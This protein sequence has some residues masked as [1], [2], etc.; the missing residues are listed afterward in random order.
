[1]AFR[2][3]LFAAGLLVACVGALFAPFLG[4]LG[5]IAH[6][7][8]GPEYQWW[9]KPLEGL[10]IRYSVTLAVAT[11]LGIILNF[12]KLKFGRSFFARQEVLLLLFLGIVWLSAA[13]G[14]PTSRA[15]YALIDHPSIKLTKVVIFSL[16]LT[17]VMTD[18]RNLNRLFWLCTAGAL[19]L[20]L[21]AYYTPWSQFVSGRLETVGGADFRGANSLSSYMGCMLPIIGATFLQA[22][23]PGRLLCLVSGAF[24][25]NAIILDRS[26]GAF[27]GIA[28]GALTCLVF[29]PKRLRLKVIL[30]LVVAAAGFLYLSNPQFWG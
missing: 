18:L 4:V 10:G 11:G 2:T 19:V 3:I 21:Q 28:A 13:M 14:E 17:H 23:W 20:G 8:I 5:Y 25:A 29:V 6:Y 15:T 16:M 7:S 30:G 9:E 27:V 22:A 12:R 26:R 1:M 24:A